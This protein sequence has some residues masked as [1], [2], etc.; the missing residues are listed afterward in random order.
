RSAI[1]N[2][3]HLQSFYRLTTSDRFVKFYSLSFDGSV[4]QIFAPLVSG[5]AT[6]IKPDSVLDAHEFLKL[7]CRSR[8]TIID[9]V[10]QFLACLLED[11]EEFD[12][13]WEQSAIRIVSTGADAM[14]QPLL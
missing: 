4:E 12:A 5:G 7:L 11:D 2:F 9:V 1:D 8:A 3:L 13:L 6:I 10:P 14:Q